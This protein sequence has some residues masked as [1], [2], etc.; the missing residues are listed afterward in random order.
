MASFKER[1]W[2]TPNPHLSCA[3]GRSASFW[4]TFWCLALRGMNTGLNSTRAHTRKVPLLLL[5]K[6]S[7]FLG[8]C[9]LPL[10]YPS[11][12]SLH[13]TLALCWNSLTLNIP[14]KMLTPS[15]WNPEISKLVFPSPPITEKVSICQVP[16]II[17]FPRKIS[18]LLVCL[19]I[20][21]SSLLPSADGGIRLVQIGHIGTSP[22]ELGLKW[23]F[24]S[25]MQASQGSFWDQLNFNSLRE[26]FLSEQTRENWMG[27]CSATWRWGWYGNK[28]SKNDE[29]QIIFSCYINSCVKLLWKL[30]S[31]L[32]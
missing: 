13:P 32:G 6:C 20:L 10:F 5:W 2:E 3:L 31:K 30:S 9:P 4:A 11:L 26:K 29:T 1:C 17:C 22:F 16:L 23:H 14:P 18:N 7:L 24:K 19:S 28:G 25:D 27:L 8:S 21:S 15:L 12:L